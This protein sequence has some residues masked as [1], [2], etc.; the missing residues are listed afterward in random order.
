MKHIRGDALSIPKRR[1]GFPQIREGSGLC[2]CRKILA[3]RGGWTR[4]RAAV[5]SRQ[6]ENS[7]EPE[8]DLTRRDRGDRRYFGPG[9]CRNADYY[10]GGWRTDAGNPH[11]YQFVIDGSKVTGV[12]CTNCADGTTLAPIEGTFNEAGGLD[13]TI[14]H[15]DLGGQNPFD[16]PAQSASSRAAS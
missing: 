1:P 5:T 4:D 7:N 12:Y 14:R 9:L 6:G 13:F 15:L 16:R 2:P 10:R 11:I 3:P 8:H